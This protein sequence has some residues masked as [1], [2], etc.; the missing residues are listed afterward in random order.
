M[1]VLPYGQMSLWGLNFKPQ[2]YNIC[3][4]YL[5]ILIYSNLLLIS[6]Q[7][8]SINTAVFIPYYGKFSRLKGKYRI[9][10]HNKDILSIIFGS[11]LGDAYGERREKGTGTRI[12][13]YQESSHVEYILHLHR[14]LSNHG[15]CNPKVP[16]I[17]T[18]LGVG[19][20]VR[21]IVRFSTWTYTSFNWI[22]ELWYV[23]GIKCVPNCINTYL[24]PL[25]LATWIMD[26]GSK[27]GKGLKFSTNTYTYEDCLKLVNALNENFEIKCSIQSAGVE[28]QYILYV[29]KESMAKLRK[30][31]N[32]HMVND[33]RYK[34][35]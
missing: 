31:V 24:T 11:L 2:M 8:R 28:G 34:I 14:L 33:M 19:G 20:K 9:G 29:W 4:I 12:T 5:F 22:H 13:F 16:V 23:K 27:V 26:D 3:L 18:R 35:D 30:I 25:A 1:Y 15:Y 7:H 32:P 21:K 17:G 6:P 10:P